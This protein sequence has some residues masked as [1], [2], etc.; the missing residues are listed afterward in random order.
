MPYGAHYLALETSYQFE[1]IYT[2]RSARPCRLVGLDLHQ[3]QSSAPGPCRTNHTELSMLTYYLISQSQKL[4]ILNKH[5][6]VHAPLVH[7]YLWFSI[8]M[9]D[10]GWVKVIF[11]LSFDLYYLGIIN[12]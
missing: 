5:D 6:R 8:R 4:R 7:L 3:S 12:Y 11:R 10:M 1:V 9:H 2:Y